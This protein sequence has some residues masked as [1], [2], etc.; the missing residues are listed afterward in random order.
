M[1]HEVTT[2]DRLHHIGLGLHGY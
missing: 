1:K 2:A